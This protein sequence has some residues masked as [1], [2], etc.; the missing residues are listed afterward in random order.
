MAIPAMVVVAATTTA[1][2]LLVSFAFQLLETKDP[3]ILTLIPVALIT[4]A[5]IKAIAL[6]LQVLMT[7]ALGLR[8]VKDLQ[9]AMFTKVQGLDVAQLADT[10]GGLLV[11]RF[12][13]DVNLAKEA[14]VRAS[15]NLVRDVLVILGALAAMLYLNWQLALIVLLLYPLASLPVI[16]LG[17]RVRA[18]SLAAQHQIGELTALLTESFAGTQMVR[19]FALE[20]REQARAKD[21]FIQRYKLAIQLTATKAAVDPFLEVL[22]ALALAVVLGFAGWRAMSGVSVIPELMGFI[23]AL[24]T[25]APSA[26]ALGT[27]N[28][29][30][31]EGMA[32]MGRA[33]ALLDQ[34]PQI[35]NIKAAKPLRFKTGEVRLD[36]VS[37]AYGQ[38]QPALRGV[39]LTAKPGQTLALVGPSGGGKTSVFNLLLRLYDPQQGQVLIAGQDIAKAELASV[40]QAISVVAQHPVLFDDTVR[41]NIAFGKLSASDAQIEAAA[42]AAAAFDFI[43]ALPNGFDSKVGENGNRLSGGQRQRIAIARAILKDAPI[44]LLD[45]ATSALDSTNEA[46]VQQ[47]LAKLC[48]GR[49]T[50]VIA[51]RLATVQNA[52]QIL[53][54]EQGQIVERGTNAELLALNGKYTKLAE[55]QLR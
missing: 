53:L 16:W 46:Q 38:D 11:S 15:N 36:N 20:Q 45:E 43:S 54:L 39:S 18:L 33:F 50:L 31:Q 21:G 37:F 32:A 19:T 9:L 7:N 4:V 24:A 25:L 14:L 29:V 42:K 1:Y 23:T 10:A 51:H 3:R 13:N 8:V 17:K 44:L 52:D 55:G 47:A 48:A 30:W 40:R 41:A 5:T 22:G 49:T 12:I 34:T 27:L 2:P 26:R 28:A 6:Y 35:T